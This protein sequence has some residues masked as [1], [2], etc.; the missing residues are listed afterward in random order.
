MKGKKVLVT[1]AGGFIG[2]H[3]IEKLVQSGYTTKA[4]IH[5]N[6]R[7]HWGWLE[8]SKYKNEIE[9]HMGDIREFDSVFKAIKDCNTIFHLAALIGIPYSYVSPLAYIRTNIEGTYNVLECAKKIPLDNI[10]ITSTSE[11][12]GTA[13]YIPID[14]EH[15]INPQSPYSATKVAADQIALSYLRSF[16]LPVKIIRPFNTYGPR[17][18]ARAIIPSIISQALTNDKIYL[19][20][21]HPT[22]DLTYVEDII[23]G[24]INVAKSDKC[25]GEVINVGSSIEV[26]IGDLANKILSIIGKKAKISTDQKRIRSEKSEVTRLCADISKAKELIGWECNISLQKGLKKTIT[27]IENHLDIYKT[28]LYNI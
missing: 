21:L 13:Q 9:V 12:Y 8:N 1:G 20:S 14:E 25:L 19:G 7:N 17:Q 28:N 18:S 11:I 26:S 4:F 27:W 3:L 2:S 16:D 5:Y 15:P 24:F 10:L 6:S 22:R 23:N